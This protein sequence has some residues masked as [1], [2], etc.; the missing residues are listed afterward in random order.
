MQSVLV[1]I[2]AV[3]VCLFYLASIIGVDVHDDHESGRTYVRLVIQG[4][5]CSDIHS[6]S[7]CHHAH[8]GECD[9]D[10]DCC[11]DEITVLSVS[12]EDTD[13]FPI[14]IPAAVSFHSSV[15]SIPSPQCL[16]GKS[17]PVLRRMPPPGC[18]FTGI[19][20]LKA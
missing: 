16:R 10:E 20:L 9:E 18:P 6:D 8:A 5:S 13:G 17:L 15:I 1:K 11:T 2:A 4:I 12:G 14:V 7:P 19:C 3:T